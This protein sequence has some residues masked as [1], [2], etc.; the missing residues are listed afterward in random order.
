[1]H[2]LVTETLDASGTPVSITFS[3]AYSFAQ[4]VGGAKYWAPAAPYISAAVGNAPPASDIIAINTARTATITYSQAMTDPLIGLVS[5]NGNTVNFGV[6]IEIISFGAGF[7]GDGTPVLNAGGTGFFGSGEVHDA[8][9]LPGTYT[10]V[11]FTHTS[12]N[13]HGLT[14]GALG[15]AAVGPGGKPCLFHRAHGPGSRPSNYFLDS[16]RPGPGPRR[17]AAA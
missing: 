16:A 9:R 12:E 4:V 13:W 11:N 5:W 17:C 15:A 1:V 10:S 14:V 8:I 3:G 2:P 6:P 7:F